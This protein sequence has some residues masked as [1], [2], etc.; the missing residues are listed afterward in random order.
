M[1][2]NTVYMKCHFK[3]PHYRH[4]IFFVDIVCYFI[5]HPF[6]ILM[7]RLCLLGS[8][9]KMLRAL[10]NKLLLRL[11]FLAFKTEHNLTSS[12]RL[13]VEDRLRLTTETHLLR[14]VTSLSLSKVRRLTGLVLSNFVH[15]ML[16]AFGAEGAA[17]FWDIDHLGIEL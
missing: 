12:F 15:T 17:F 2:N 5:V 14:V 16:L 6:L 9:L 4:C 11:T 8:E 13:F 7:A 1:E 3:C 10:K